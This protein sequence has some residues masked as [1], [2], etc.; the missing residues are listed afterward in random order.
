[1][2]VSPLSSSGFLSSLFPPTQVPPEQ[3]AARN[4]LQQTNQRTSIDNLPQKSSALNISASER[5]SSAES[6][7]LT[8]Q[9]KEGDN[10]TINF[11]NQA[12]FQASIAG[13]RNQNGSAASISLETSSS[14]NF[15]FSVEGDLNEDEQTAINNLV[16]EL[17]GIADSFFSGNVQDAFN[18]AA[19]FKLDG[20]QLASIDF[21]L[22]QNQSYSRT[23]AYESIQQ[24]SEPAQLTK[25]LQPLREGLKEQLEN[26]EQ[27]IQDASEITRS[28]LNTLIEQ[29]S[30]YSQ[31]NSE[32]QQQLDENL[33]TLNVLI[34][35]LSSQTGDS[36]S[37]QES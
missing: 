21:K 29:D 9:T 22:S 35:N 15:R 28:L 30:R 19:D 36:N 27:V 10:V 4:D 6:F 3:S 11:S 23:A 13:T 16:K 14:S 17:S 26:A 34:N 7:S 18:N 32:L 25:A 1:M 2:D 37:A 12:S 24:L 8:L 31:A 5:F 33:A 20:S